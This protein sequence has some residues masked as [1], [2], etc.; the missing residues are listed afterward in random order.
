MYNFHLY[1]I[2]FQLVKFLVL[3]GANRYISCVFHKTPFNTTPAGIRNW[4]MSIRELSAAEEKARSAY[5]KRK[6][7]LAANEKEKPTSR[8][9]ASEVH[10]Q[11]SKMILRKRCRN[12]ED[13][14]ELLR[15][16]RDLCLSKYKYLDLDSSSSGP[17]GGSGHPILLHGAVDALC[18]PV[19]KELVECRASPNAKNMKGSTPLH[20][21]CMRLPISKDIVQFLVV[22]GGANRYIGNI[23]GKTPLDLIDL[24][25]QVDWILEIKPLSAEE[26]LFEKEQNASKKH[27]KSTLS[28]ISNKVKEK[29]RLALVEMV[30]KKY[31]KEHKA[32]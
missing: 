21:A 19:V 13:I 29:N 16:S 32:I 30:G 11:L 10:D 18:L 14:V 3:N 28:G 2:Q 23:L 22:S 20:R 12:P 1:L 9:K 31:C 15:K 6:K 7:D 4:F 26:I 5:L 24:K 8:K 27:L 25:E 17:K